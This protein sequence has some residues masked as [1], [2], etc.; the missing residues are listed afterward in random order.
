MCTTTTIILPPTRSEQHHD[1]VGAQDES[2]HTVGSGLLGPCGATVRVLD[3]GSARV[4]P[5]RAAV[6]LGPVAT[7]H[8]NCWRSWLAMC[9]PVDR[10]T[11]YIIRRVGCT[12]LDTHGLAEDT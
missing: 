1:S 5:R 2:T 8:F 6:V 3:G 7:L 4:T 11:C 12:L 9:P 10:E